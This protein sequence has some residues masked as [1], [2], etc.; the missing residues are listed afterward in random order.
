MEVSVL[1]D[2]VF[3]VLKDLY[4][5]LG[6]NSKLEGQ[7]LRD[8]N[9][10]YI[11]NKVSWIAYEAGLWKPTEKLRQENEIC[12]GD[13]FPRDD[14]TNVRGI[15]WRLVGL[16]VLTPRSIHDEH[17]QFFELTG[18]G[19]QVI[20]DVEESPYD[21]LGFLQRL[22]LDSP[23]LEPNSIEFV[24]EAINCFLTRYFQAAAVLIGLASENEIL[25]LLQYHGRTLDMIGKAS[26]EKK[27]ALSTSIKRKF[28]ILYDGL[29]QKKSKLPPE[30]RELD[31]WLQ[32]IFHVIRLYRNDAGH[33]IGNT[34]SSEDVYANLVLFRKYAYYL[35]KLKEH[36][37]NFKGEESQSSEPSSGLTELPF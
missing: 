34:S 1:Q 3:Q 37:S 5:R 28:D 7:F 17:N 36:L 4:V 20:L 13:R 33:P 21:P 24:R 26:L 16:G 10:G 12:T 11:T 31:V 25:S 15:L 2:M 29:F 35:S 27:L 19:K 6:N 18:Y 30:V 14:V 32:G 22:T 8:L 23:Y 9:T